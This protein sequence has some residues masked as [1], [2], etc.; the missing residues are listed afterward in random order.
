VL[1]KGKLR[2]K[3]NK[4]RLKANGKHSKPREKQVVCVWNVGNNTTHNTDALNKS[5]TC[6]G[7]VDE[8]AKGSDTSSHNSGEESL[9]L[10][11]VV[12]NGTQGKKTIRLQ[13]L[14]NHQE[15]LI[16]VD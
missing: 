11:L 15:I 10:S 16:L 6:G 9:Q 3:T 13:G 7:R 8:D 14:I 12:T 1:T 5:P 2:R 4:Q